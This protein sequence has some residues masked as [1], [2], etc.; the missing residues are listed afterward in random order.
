V[1]GLSSGIL[2]IGRIL[3]LEVGLHVANSRE[4]LMLANKLQD[5][6]DRIQA[7]TIIEAVAY[8]NRL[9]NKLRNNDCTDAERQQGLVLLERLKERTRFLKIH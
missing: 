1:K 4:H 8:V 7:M 3:P 5:E 2:R 9:C 6:L